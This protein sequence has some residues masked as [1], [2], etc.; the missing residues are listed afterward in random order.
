MEFE[1]FQEAIA[2]LTALGPEVIQTPQE[3]PENDILVGDSE[4]P[5]AVDLR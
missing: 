2:F 5:R 3:T 4:P 1:S